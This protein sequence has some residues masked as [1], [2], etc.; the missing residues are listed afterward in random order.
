MLAL[1]AA[2]M[3]SHVNQ[4]Y[5]GLHR[6]RRS[7][8]L[9]WDV[10]GSAA[11]HSPPGFLRNTSAPSTRP[12]GNNGLAINIYGNNGAFPHIATDGSYANGGLPQLC[13]LTA[14]M[15]KL[16]ADLEQLI[17][18]PGFSGYC[19][20][21][22]EQLRADWNST[23]DI[24]RQASIV[25][26]NGDVTVAQHQYESAARA[27]FLATIATTRT[28]R[29]GCRVGWYGYPK[30]SLPHTSTPAW[31][32][33]C[34]SSPSR[35]FFDRGGDGLD[36]GYI[37]PG[38]LAQRAINDGL[39]WLFAALDIV[40]PAVYLGIPGLASTTGTSAYVSSTVME[41]VRVASPNKIPVF[42]ATWYCY[43]NYWQV[44]APVDRQ[45]L[46]PKDL[47]VELAGPL[48]A[49]ASGLLLWGNIDPRDNGTMGHAALANYSAP[50]GIL[51]AA[52]ATICTEFLCA[53]M[54]PP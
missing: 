16:T 35:C 46:S 36:S 41:A 2:M 28:V 44:P 51:A 4:P 10:D 17:P 15:E 40:T 22:F 53:P 48:R 33:Y 52:S 18:D 30:N 32:R 27:L 47:A 9:I 26:A 20:L 12:V 19:L 6:H 37:G 3:A 1:G 29:K 34:A 21:D 38:G 5:A 42:P 39:S 23:Q 49:G 43:D 54:L 31:R 24:Y 13:N 50:G 7:V 45:L 8:A 14:H 11:V 25:Q